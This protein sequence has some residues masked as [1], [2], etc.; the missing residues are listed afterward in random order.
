MTCYHVKTCTH[1]ELLFFVKSYYLT[2]NV[3]ICLLALAKTNSTIRIMSQ[4]NT[5]NPE[6]CQLLSM[7]QYSGHK[8]HSPNHFHLYSLRYPNQ[9]ETLTAMNGP[10]VRHWWIPISSPYL[11][12][13]LIADN[14]RMTSS[15]QH[16]FHL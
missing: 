7:L 16:V 14:L 15:S 10:K 6:Y 5:K 8:Q 12:W 1:L 9:K 2:I 11:R 4:S 13:S 3:E